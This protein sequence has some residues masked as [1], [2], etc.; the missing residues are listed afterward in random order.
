MNF[1]KMSSLAPN[2]FLWGGA[3]VA[4]LM[5]FTEGWPKIQNTFYEKIPYFGQHWVDN[6]PAEDKPN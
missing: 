4:G 1:G 3:W 2:L 5:V 6:T